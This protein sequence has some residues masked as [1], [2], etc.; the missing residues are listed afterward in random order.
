MRVSVC[1]DYGQL[2]Y[3]HATCR[4]V[5]ND[6]IAYEISYLIAG[7]AGGVCM[8]LYLNVLSQMGSHADLFKKV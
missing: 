8:V 1:P 4:Y 6:T 3:E 2:W 7:Q 5:Q